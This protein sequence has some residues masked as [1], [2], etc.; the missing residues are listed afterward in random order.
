[1]AHGKKSR[2]R[3][4]E[5]QLREKRARKAAQ[6]ALYESR[7]RAGINGKSKRYLRNAKGGGQRGERVQA[8]VPVLIRGVWTQT[9]RSVH[10]GSNCGNV[11]CKKCSPLWTNGRF[12]R[13]AA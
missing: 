12:L 5:K 1:M 7:R 3:N 10:A 11:G 4:R 2:A 6:T 9:L 8:L 13:K